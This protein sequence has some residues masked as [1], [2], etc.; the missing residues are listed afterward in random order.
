[1]P[2][3]KSTCCYCGVGCGVI[4]EHDRER[5]T[6]VRGDPDHPAN[7]GRLCTK[8]TTLHLT[9]RPEGRAL[10]PELRLERDAPRARVGGDQALDHAARRF[11]DIIRRH[12]PDAVA[13]YVS[14]Q[15]LTEDYYVFN[16]LAKALVGSNN[17]DTNSRLCMSS[18]VAAYKQT[19][20]ADTPPCCY[21]DIA[22]ADCI[23]IAGS[24]TAYAHPVTYRRIED[25]KRAN[26]QLKIVVID[27]RR[28][29]TA[30]GAD[31]HLPIL[32][33]SDI[34]LLNALLHVLL[35]EGLVDHRYIRDHTEGFEQLRDAVR[36]VTPAAAAQVCGVPAED[37]VT[38]AR[39]FGNARAALSLWCQG[40]NQSH[41]GTHNGAALIHLH[42]ATG[43]IGRPGAG[44]FSL[45]GQPNAMGGRE[46]GGMA[47][48]LPA[49]R[50]L[51]N[52]EHRAEVARLWGVDSIPEKPGKTA[53]ELF[54]AMRQG[55]IKAVWIA[56]TN[57]AQSLP[58]QGR[59]REALSRCQFVV[60]QEAYTNTETADF[61]DLL[62]PAATWGEK[63]GTVT[64]SERRISHVRRAIAAPAEALPD[65]Q[66][67]RDFALRL[68]QRLGR[69]AARLFP[70][71]HP[72]QVF[73]E[74]AETTRG[75]DL[76][77]T[78]LSYAVL[79]RAGP[80][81]W[82]FPETAHAGQ[83][84]LYGDGRFCTS[85]GRARF[86]RLDA[87]LTA[88]ATHARMPLHL[89]TGRLRDQ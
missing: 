44:P 54:E 29:D 86:I 48:L 16:K 9:T 80:Q 13:F 57:P 30:A 26:P 64:N 37:I 66:I 40:L 45:T 3:T 32:P 41:H 55:E 85:S 79:D 46:V 25:A 88:E 76:D 15:M 7:F 18:A 11:A 1:M 63:E 75:R 8:G 71:F 27:P 23:V 33:G 12:G 81:Q 5:I 58:D 74:H 42:L 70:Y 22:H 83:A 61:A 72:E 49:H 59:V 89:N 47:N 73:L 53:V 60:L 82:P 14:G 52:P 56:C 51:S 43:Q 69:D 20:G 6:R 28:T 68:G 67:G 19:L 65:W 38:A 84:R 35:W 34:V 10:Y 50:D 62:L 31:L 24:N 36:E 39:W 2:E 78:G 17:I 77:I 4:I 87:A 21:D